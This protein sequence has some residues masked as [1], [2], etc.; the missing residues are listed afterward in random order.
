MGKLKEELSRFLFEKSRRGA[1]PNTSWTVMWYLSSW[2]K[3]THHSYRTT[4]IYQYTRRLS[5]DGASKRPPFG[6][7]SCSWAQVR[8]LIRSKS[9][10][11]Y[12]VGLLRKKHGDWLHRGR[13]RALLCPKLLASLASAL[14]I[15]V[16]F[17][18]Y[19][20]FNAVVDSSPGYCSGLGTSDARLIFSPLSAKTRLTMPTI[21]HVTKIPWFPLL[22]QQI[23]VAAT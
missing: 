5:L 19:S 9:W 11:Y 15:R 2:C 6:G 7:G 13:G 23:I 17:V 22:Q 20:A 8:Y 14:C 16:Y 1:E 4:G 21:P 18:R 10:S 12:P 3:V